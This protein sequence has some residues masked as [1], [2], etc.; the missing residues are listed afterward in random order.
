MTPTLA[1]PPELTALFGALAEPNRRK[2]LRLVA[3]REHTVG[4]LVSALH[5]L[6]AAWAASTADSRSAVVARA[7]V[8]TTRPS[9]GDLI[10]ERAPSLAGRRSALMSRSR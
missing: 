4:E 2:V 5:V 3:V 10:S 7:T 9:C 6:N 1:E 8:A